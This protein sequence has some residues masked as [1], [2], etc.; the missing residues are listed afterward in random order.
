MTGQPDI[1]MKKD[2][3]PKVMENATQWQVLD[4]SIAEARAS[5]ADLPPDELQDLIG[6]AIR[7]GRHQEQE[8]AM[9]GKSEDTD[10]KGSC[11]DAQA[12]VSPFQAEDAATGQVIDAVN[13]FHRDHGLLSDEFP[14]L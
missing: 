11:A 6:E 9:L 1:R 10:M 8:P 13:A 14:C 12:G 2:N 4:E 3:P 5:F 7:S